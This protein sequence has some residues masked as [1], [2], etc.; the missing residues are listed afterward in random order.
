MDVCWYHTVLYLI[1]FIIDFIFSTR[2]KLVMKLSFLYLINFAFAGERRSVSH[3]E[4]G[5]TDP[6]EIFR[7]AR[8][9]YHRHYRK[10][11]YHQ[12]PIQRRRSFFQINRK[13]SI[14]KFLMT[15]KFWVKLRK[16]SSEKWNKWDKMSNVQKR[17]FYNS[18]SEHDKANILL[19]VHRRIREFNAFNW[20]THRPR[21]RWPL[22]GAS[23]IIDCWIYKTFEFVRHES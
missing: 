19:S 4:R 16:N 14:R 2:N 6:E 1:V 18:L 3:G 13:Y 10:P 22:E 5:M 20:L 8:S 17:E 9:Y 21:M 7:A 12:S 11:T 15:P 23:R